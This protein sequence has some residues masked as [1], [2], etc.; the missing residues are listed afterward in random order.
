[1][2]QR[3][4]V[5]LVRVGKDDSV[6]LHLGPIEP[7]EF[8]DKNP[9]PQLGLLGKHHPTIDDDRAARTFDRHQ[10]EADLAQP[11]E[12]NQSDRNAYW[13]APR[14]RTCPPCR[15]TKLNYIAR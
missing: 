9:A 1:M 14:H 15:C 10:V 8:R 6:D 13:S 2:R 7:G 3:P 11:T 12:R 4:D 5:I